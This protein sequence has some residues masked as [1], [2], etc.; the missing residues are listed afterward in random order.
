MISEREINRLCGSFA[1]EADMAGVVAEWAR[2]EG[3]SVTEEPQL[4]CWAGTPDL[5][6]E[7]D[8]EFVV[9]E[10]KT[11]VTTVLMAQALAWVEDDRQV[12]GVYVCVPDKWPTPAFDAMV[13]VL[14]DYGVGVL[15]ARASTGD[16]F[17]KLEA[18]VTRAVPHCAELA[19]LIDSGIPG[20]AGR[21]GCDQR[22]P[23]SAAVIDA[24]MEMRAAGIDKC[25]AAG[26]LAETFASHRRA[27]GDVDWERVV[28]LVWGVTRE[29]I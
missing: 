22:L 28:S 10:C 21:K 20:G 12:A 19:W 3:W 14:G 16:V 1:S 26:V 25:D 2:G 4:C 11:H 17:T 18:R 29:D 15:T 23:I 8:G 7:R 9:I 6:C 13:R 27:R 24:Q 5:L